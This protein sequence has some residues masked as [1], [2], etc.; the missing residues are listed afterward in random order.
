MKGERNNKRNFGKST[1]AWKINKLFLTNQW[2]EGEIQ[3]DEASL[4]ECLASMPKARFH[5]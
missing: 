1:K 5:S 2:V 4:R 3:I